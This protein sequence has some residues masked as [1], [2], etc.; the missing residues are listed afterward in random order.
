MNPAPATLVCT[1]C[2]TFAPA[3]D[4]YPFRCPNAGRGNDTDHVM[5]V[6][7]DPRRVQFP[8]RDHANPFI[9]YRE[10]FYSYHFALAHGL[11]DAD[12][13][14]LV[15]RLDR[16]VARLDG[17]GFT[18]TPFGRSGPL[19]RHFQF[20][21]D[22]GVWVKDE[23]GN[24]SGSHKARHLMGLLIYLQAAEHLRLAKHRNGIPDLAIA[25]CGNAA[26]AAAVVARAADRRLRV[27]VPSKA[28][29][30]IIARL[31]QLDAQ[32]TVCP[33]QE[34]V[35]GDP[36]Y[37]ALQQAV[38]D[39]AIP[40]TCQGPDNGL[41][42]EGGKTLAYEMASALRD[43]D[44]YLDR[45]FIQVGGGALASATIQGWLDAVRLGAL[46]MMPR[47]H[48]VQ[49]LSCYPLRRAY[50]LLV[51]RLLGR[52]ERDMDALPTSPEA[53]RERAEFIRTA[54]PPDVVEEALRY[55]ATH[56][57][58]FM[59]PWEHEPRSIATGILDDET[60][61]WLAIVRGMVTTGGYP[62]VVSEHTL[63]EAND[64]ARTLTGI[65]VD[66]TGSAG[67]AGLAHLMREGGV[68]RDERVGVLFTGVQR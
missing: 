35:A 56:R 24:V 22:G 14:A 9:R 40:F 52:L 25:S 3:G 6:R 58:E 53:D 46:P 42:I 28:D 33:R 54:A 29:P 44:R 4:P 62:V 43:A 60:Y 15:E 63:A 50:D 30:K 27:F 66:P 67:L 51:R 59:W 18:A 34:G 21:D 38:R 7:L 61:D 23:T 10:L 36:A 20:S 65:G 13:V 17:G 16:A 19:S 68:R 64:L 2:G 47:I 45:L 32:I 26:L 55:A 5:T 48:T 8:E 1:G 11:T 57:S 39:G 31:R 37:H 41:T 49:T 12:Y